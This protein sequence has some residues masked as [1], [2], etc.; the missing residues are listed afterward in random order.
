MY[1]SAKICQLNNH[2]MCKSMAKDVKSAD[3]VSELKCP[4]P[5]GYG[6]K[7]VGF[8]PKGTRGNARA[9]CWKGEQ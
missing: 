1:S 5:Y 3:N 2:L 4:T 6:M 8:G 9:S 7:P